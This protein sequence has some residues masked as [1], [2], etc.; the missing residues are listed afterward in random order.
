MNIYLVVILAVNLSVIPVTII[1]AVEFTAFYIPLIFIAIS[2][3]L[4]I[5]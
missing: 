5:R 1:F 2:L 4:N 3:V